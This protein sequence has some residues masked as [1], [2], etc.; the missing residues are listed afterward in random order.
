ME[1]VISF[2]GLGINELHIN[3]I[4]LQIGNITVTWYGIIITVG[5]VLAVLYVFRR[6]Q[7]LGIDGDTILD[8]AIPTVI[9][10]VIGCKSLLC[11]NNPWRGKVS[12]FLRCDCTV[13]RRTCH[14]WCSHWW[15]TGSICDVPHQK[16]PL[17]FF[18]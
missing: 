6:A 1:N 4:A 3:K 13:E 9:C 8:I 16:N 15:R 5:I 18:G 12:Q 10:G 11:V 2:P 7:R 14:L 17:S